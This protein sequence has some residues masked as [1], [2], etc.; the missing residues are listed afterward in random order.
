MDQSGGWFQHNRND[1]LD[2]R[3]VVFRSLGIAFLVGA[4]LAAVAL[5]Y[6]FVLTISAIVSWAIMLL[7]VH[8]T[9]PQ[10]ADD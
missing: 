1:K 4:L 2:E 7:V 8:L 9:E 3:A 5:L 6:R 10:D